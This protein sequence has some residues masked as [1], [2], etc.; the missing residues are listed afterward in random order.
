MVA[1]DAVDGAEGTAEFD[2]GGWLVA[3]GDEGRSRRACTLL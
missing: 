1:D 3:G 2:G